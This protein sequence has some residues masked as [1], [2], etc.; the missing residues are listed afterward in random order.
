M[1]ELDGIH[2]RS[3]SYLQ[4]RISLL[5]RLAYCVLNYS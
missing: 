2:W 1:D 5:L 3:T 4:V